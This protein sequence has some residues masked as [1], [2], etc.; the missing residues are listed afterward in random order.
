MLFFNYIM[1]ADK[2]EN[3]ANVKKCPHTT[4]LHTHIHTYP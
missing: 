2:D 1:V 4:C 3:P